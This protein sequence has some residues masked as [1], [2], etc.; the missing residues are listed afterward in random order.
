MKWTLILCFTAVLFGQNSE[1]STIH[2]LLNQWHKAA[3][4]ADEELFFGSMA[5]DAIYL[6]TDK[7]ER[8]LRDELKAWSAKYFERDKAW[9][10]KP[11]DRH[12]YFSVDGKTAWFEESLETWMDVCRGSGVLEKINGVWRIKHYHL[13]VTIDNDLI[14]DF[15]SLVTKERTRPQ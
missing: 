4:T 5:K 3:A 6:G 9:D 7:S 2:S 8:W 1:E 15:I 10:F 13:S 14:K 11:Y 12:I